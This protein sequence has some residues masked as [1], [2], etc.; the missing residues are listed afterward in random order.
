MTDEELLTV[1]GLS[2]SYGNIQVIED[3]NAT[4]SDGDIVS[5]VG[6]NGAGKT[7]LLK[8]ISGVKQPMDGTIRYRGEDITAAH[9]HQ[10][11]ERGIT[12]VPERHRIFSE[13]TVHENLVTAS[14]A[15]R[16]RDR[17][18]AFERVF[19]LFPILRER[20]EQTAGTLSGGQQQMLA[21]SQGLI[22][23]PDV[24]MLDEPTLGL[25]PQIVDRIHETIISINEEGT[26]V[27]ISD[28]QIEMPMAV[29]D[30]MYLM[31]EN[32][33]RYLGEAGE[34]E[35]KYEEIRDETLE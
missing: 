23:D 5:I 32:T 35:S 14:V 11:I 16:D 9:P 8:T 30:R 3:A 26:T 21:I 17:E 1:D 24:I 19:G 27:I 29:S 12:Y 20:R 31:R 10:V 13:M 22:A 15:A 34:F 7:T 6:A 4:V 18:R 33:L 28:E 2:V 25:A